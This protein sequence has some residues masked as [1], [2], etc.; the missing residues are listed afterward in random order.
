MGIT[1]F[2]NGISVGKMGLNKDTSGATTIVSLGS[3]IA[4]DADSFVKAATSTELP[5]AATKTY[6]AATIGTSP[7]DAANTT[8]VLDS[9]RNITAACTHA[10]SVVAMTITITGKDIYGATMSEALSITAGTTSK[11]AAGAKAFK[12]I[13]SI[14]ITAAGDATA[15]TL[16]I[17]HGDVLGL[18][19]VMAKN[20]ILREWRAGTVATAGT[21]VAAVTT[22]PATTTTGDVRGTVTPNAACDGTLHEVMFCP[23]S[24]T[25]LGVKQA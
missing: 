14:A 16:N 18:P 23:T 19:Y 12:T 9:A 4:L 5:N 15:N 22:D 13:T 24:L 3:P 6:T 10:S 8:W 21:I 17:G 1:K 2:P 25:S 7:L 20:T 11:S